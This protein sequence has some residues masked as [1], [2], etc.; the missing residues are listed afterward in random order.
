MDKKTN[1]L[2]GS[3]MSQD[4]ARLAALVLGRCVLCAGPGGTIKLAVVGPDQ[5]A[6]SRVETVVALKANPKLP[7][8]EVE[9]ASS[10]GKPQIAL[11][12]RADGSW[13]LRVL[14]N[15]PVELSSR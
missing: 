4:L 8:L 6:S 12:L 9:L 3:T 5:K 2:H 11:E 15:N 7:N 13:K 14:G 1:R 10:D